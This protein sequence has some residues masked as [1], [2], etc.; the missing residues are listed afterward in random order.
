M[1]ALL[2]LSHLFY[3]FKTTT[4]RIADKCFEGNL[5]I[6]KIIRF[7]WHTP[8]S[9]L[10]KGE[11]SMAQGEFRISPVGRGD[12]RP[13]NLQNLD[14]GPGGRLPGGH[15][16]ES[17]HSTSPVRILKISFSIQYRMQEALNVYQQAIA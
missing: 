7:Q 5:F 10:G 6:N 12:I 13:R 16:T 2:T 4:K 8:C 9:F 14:G 1:F 11:G 3:Q 15:S 17:T